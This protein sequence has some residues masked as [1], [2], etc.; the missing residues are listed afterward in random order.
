MTRKDKLIP[1][2]LKRIQKTVV[3]TLLA[4]AEKGDAAAIAWLDHSGLIDLT[5]DI[6]KIWGLLK[7]AQP[8]PDTGDDHG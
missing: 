4:K 1:D 3:E 6:E 7:Q 2:K 8:Q 5:D